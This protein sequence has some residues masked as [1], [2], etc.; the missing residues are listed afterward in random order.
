MR[1]QEVSLLV[2]D[3]VNAMRVQMRE[4]LKSFGFEIIHLASNGQ[5]AKQILNEQKVDFIL[6]D[7]H[8]GAFNGIDFLKYVRVEPKFH[9][10]PFVMITASNTKEEVLGAI[11]AGVDDY[12]VKPL[13]LDQIQE[14]VFKVLVRK[15]VLL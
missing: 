7:W 5:E 10:I 8:M 15:K 3:D 13:T 11:R 4:L 14:K 6:C 1:V 2:A 12:I 9:K